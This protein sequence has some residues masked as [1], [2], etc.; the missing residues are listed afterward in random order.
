MVRLEAKYLRNH[1][2]LTKGYPRD[3]Y[4]VSMTFPAAIVRWPGGRGVR[5]VRRRMVKVRSHHLTILLLAR[6]Q[7]G[8]MMRAQ[9]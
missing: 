4:F 9:S 1:R 7:Y 8:F 6:D 5:D 3:N 2:W